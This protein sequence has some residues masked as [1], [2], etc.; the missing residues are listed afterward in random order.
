[1]KTCNKTINILVTLDSN[2]VGPLTVMLFSLLRSNPFEKFD[3]YVAHSSLKEADF[4]RIRS[5]ADSSKCNIIPLHI[6]EKLLCNAPVLKRIT[7][8]TYYRL[9]AADYLPQEVKRILYIDPDTVVINSLRSLYDTDLGENLIMGSTHTGRF[10]E[11]VCRKRLN[12]THGSKY[13]N[14]GVLLMNVEGIRQTVKTEDIFK[15]ID[16]NAKKLY[17]ADQDVINALFCERTIIVDA[18]VFNLDEK[19]FKR[20]KNEI[21]N[22]WID[23]NTVIVHF[24]GKYK[25]WKDGYKGVLKCFF[26][27]ETAIMKKTTN[28][29]LATKMAG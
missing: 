27:R 8:E 5:V 7:K 14:A 17:L 15:Y 9:I 10:L 20:F 18:C 13:V 12:M 26:D 28:V 21:D 6:D 24:N 22:N 19:T 3:V 1:M 2:Y 25:P 4:I 29:M 16:N 11:G 23:R